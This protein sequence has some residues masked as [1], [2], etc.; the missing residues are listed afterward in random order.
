MEEVSAQKSR[1][2]W[3]C[4]A[5]GGLMPALGRLELI[6]IAWLSCVCNWPI[7]AHESLMHGEW[8][9]RESAGLGQNLVRENTGGIGSGYFG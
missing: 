9:R 8:K 7:M 5:S 3:V 6:L 4:P 1:V 2:Q